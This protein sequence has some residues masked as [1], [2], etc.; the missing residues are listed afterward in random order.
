MMTEITFTLPEASEDR[1]RTSKGAWGVGRS[2]SSEAR[3]LKNVNIQVN[4]IDPGGMGTSIQG[5][6]RALEPCV[7]GESIHFHFMEYKEKGLPKDPAEVASRAV[8]PASD[9]AET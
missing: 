1:R 2:V 9:E 7:P 5:Q 3:L 6:I 4:A 8:Y